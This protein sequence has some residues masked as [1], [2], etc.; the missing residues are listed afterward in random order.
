MALP[1][2][3]EFFLCI[4]STLAEVLILVVQTTTDSNLGKNHVV[5][6][7]VLYCFYS[8]YVRCVTILLIIDRI[9]CDKTEAAFLPSKGRTSI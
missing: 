4:S 7:D 8:W 6:K 9:S 5:T 2:E 3:S 1:T